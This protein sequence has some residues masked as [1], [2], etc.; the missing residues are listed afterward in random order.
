[1]KF[2]TVIEVR[3]KEGQYDPEGETVRKSLIDLD[4]PVSHVGTGKIYEIV[5]EANSKK[6]TEKMVKQMC[7]RLLV[8]PIKDRF[9]SKVDQIGGTAA[10]S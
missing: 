10:K 8:N 2:L 5:I 7:S 6:E 1:M 9:G 3:L 4:F